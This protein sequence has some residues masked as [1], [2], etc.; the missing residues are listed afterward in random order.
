MRHNGERRP[1]EIQAEIART[2]GDMDATLTAIE[3]R[4]TPGQL[5]DQGLDYLRNSGANEFV[6]NLGGSVKNNPIPVALMGI[7]I[8]WLMA[9]GNRKP[10]YARPQAESSAPG[11]MQR[12]SQGMSSAK[13]SV[14]QTTQSVR[15]RVGQMGQTAREQME[16]VR[17]QAE[18]VRS[19]YDSVVREQPLAL[20]AIG[21]AIGALLAAAAPRTRQE[22]ELMGEASDRLAQKAKDVGREQVAK[23][24]EVASAAKDAAPGEAEKQGRRTATAAPGRPNVIQP[25]RATPLGEGAKPKDPRLGTP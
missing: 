10:A 1:E 4:L 23:V 13:D 19:G 8:A 12:A 21:L 3:Q 20:G 25:A 24:Q 18:R 6:G 9:T 16:R 14:S 22:D 2:R 11:M 5:V 15:G 17:Y 7:G